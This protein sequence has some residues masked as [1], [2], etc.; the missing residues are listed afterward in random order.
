MSA[1]DRR[2]EAQTARI[3]IALLRGWAEFEIALTAAQR[4]GLTMEAA[5]EAA[6]TA[7]RAVGVEPPTKPV[8]A[9]EW[10]A[11]VSDY[12]ATVLGH[13]EV[14]D[15]PKLEVDVD[16]GGTDQEEGTWVCQSC[17]D[18]PRPELVPRGAA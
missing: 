6:V 3:G 12:D 11:A 5:R 10:L 18:E 13:C 8:N 9:S 15:R 2:T 17:M 16:T 14:C 4:V 7:M 1:K